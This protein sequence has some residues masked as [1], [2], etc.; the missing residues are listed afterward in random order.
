MT[1]LQTELL[2]RLAHETPDGVAWKNLDDNSE[3]TLGHWQTQSNRLAR[4]L[5]HRGVAPGNRVALAIGEERPFEW[6]I[7]YMAVHKARAVAVPLNVRLAGSEID[8]ILRHAGASALVATDALLAAHPRMASEL[9]VTV[10]IGAAG[11]LGRRWDEF[12]DPDGSDV[13]PGPGEHDEADVMYTSGTTG[14]PRGVVVRHGGLSSTDRIPSTWHGLGFITSSPFSTTSG[15]LLICGPMRAG[16]TG[17]F[18]PRF[19]PLRWL[20]V[21]ESQRPVAAF[22]VPAMVQL[23]VA[24]PHFE[25]A[26]LT[27]LFAVTIGSA[28]IA[29]ETLRRFGTRLI[30][31]DV[32]CGYGL[33]EFGAVTAMPPGDGGKHGGSVGR[34]L[35]GVS[36]RI[37]SPEGAEAPRGEVGQI[38]IQ[39]SRQP[40]SYLNDPEASTTSWRDGWLLSGDLGYL[41]A[42]GY[43]WIVGR[44][45]EIIIRGGHNIVPGE[46]ES[47]LFEHPDIVD[48]A[49]SGIPHP[50]LGEDVAAWVVPAPGTR[51]TGDEIRTFLL[52]RLADYKVPRRITFLTMLPR[53]DAGKLLKSQLVSDGTARS[54]S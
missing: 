24:E 8:G 12:L 25:S 35:P 13:D 27:S 11:I 39:G 5:T 21:V 14:T 26:D 22:L 30:N 1:L 38:T 4:G 52:D 42:D 2:A 51:P 23:I 54:T 44:Q 53:N 19:D 10:T 50:V 6:L 49:V 28:P 43:L 45:K 7:A 32:M 48:A 15:S 34:P 33:T 47:V 46:V 37:T 36:V 9:A 29:R 31:A 20:E 18:L 40:R 16:M 41:D 3:L 17:W